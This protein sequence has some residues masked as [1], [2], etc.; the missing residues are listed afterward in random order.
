MSDIRYLSTN[1]IFWLKKNSKANQR[2]VNKIEDGRL[3]IDDED[4]IAYFHKQ[5][6]NDEEAQI[7][8]MEG[9]Q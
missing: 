4:D 9:A 8:F 7:L 1:F 3:S 6:I 5:W 2:L